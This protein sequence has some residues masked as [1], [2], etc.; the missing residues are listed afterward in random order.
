MHLEVKAVIHQPERIREILKQQKA[1]FTGVDFQTDI[2]FKVPRGRLKLR[3][4]NIENALIFYERADTAAPRNSQAI[5]QPVSSDHS[6]REMLSASLGILTEVK[7]V[8][9]SYLL[10]HTKIHLDQVDKL[11]AFV[12]IEIPHPDRSADE[13]VLQ[14]EC[15]RMIGLLGLREADFCAVSYSDLQQSTEE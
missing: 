10:G 13:A 4:G 3:Q 15:H 11:G 9:E 12:E 7:K 5:T 14:E 6:L 1:R 8:R 2:Y